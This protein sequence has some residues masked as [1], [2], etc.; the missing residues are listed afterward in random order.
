MLESVTK[1]SH[2][3]ENWQVPLLPEGIQADS[4]LLN[5][6]LSRL[7]DLQNLFGDLAAI[8]LDRRGPGLH[9]IKALELLLQDVHGKR[10]P[11]V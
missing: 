7:A 8:G 1:V 9:I 2:R 10:L 6:D 11:T 4:Q 5:L 3:R